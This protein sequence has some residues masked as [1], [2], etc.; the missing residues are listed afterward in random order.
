M[1]GEGI[2]SKKDG[3]GFMANLAADKHDGEHVPEE[4]ISFVPRIFILVAE[5]C[6][7]SNKQIAEYL[8]AELYMVVS[9]CTHPMEGAL[10]A[11]LVQD[12]ELGRRGQIL[13]LW[14]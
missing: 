9:L 6:A 4:S 3:H 7:W 13:S 5:F 12:S 8:I 10:S 2:V 14:S 11:Y 1:K